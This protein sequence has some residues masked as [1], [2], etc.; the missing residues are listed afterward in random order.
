MPSEETDSSIDTPPLY[1][2][3]Y[4]ELSKF[5]E[6]KS[7]NPDGLGDFRFRSINH[8]LNPI[9]VNISRGVPA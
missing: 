5:I 7:V 2:G 9:R 8:L 1:C 3:V 4:I 6:N